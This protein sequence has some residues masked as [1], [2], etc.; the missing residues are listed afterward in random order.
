M[1]IINQTFEWLDNFFSSLGFIDNDYS[2]EE[3]SFSFNKPNN[4]VFYNLN[5]GYA[6]DKNQIS[7]DGLIYSSIQSNVV[8]SVLNKV[9]LSNNFEKIIVLDYPEHDKKFGDSDLKVINSLPV[10]TKGEFDA[11]I[12]IISDH[13]SNYILPFFNKIPKLQA[14]N[15]E[16]L[17]KVPE[18][19]YAEYIPGQTNFKVL[20]IMKLC[21]NPKYESFKNWALEAYKRGAEMD[22]SRYGADFET[23][24]SL[25]TYLDGEHLKDY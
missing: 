3:K 18:E 21:G 4:D 19:E 24:Q 2:L 12:M 9:G 22:E 13:I 25:V 17:N 23:L 15:D 16:I 20:I 8:D 1:D 10:A 6:L 7:L 14:V 5:F 11:L